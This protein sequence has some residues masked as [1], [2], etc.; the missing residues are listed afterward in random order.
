MAGQIFLIIILLIVLWL[1]FGKQ[2]QFLIAILQ[3]MI[4][5][6]ALFFVLL[7]TFHII[8]LEREK[9]QTLISTLLTISCIL[10]GRFLA[11][12]YL[13]RNTDSEDRTITI[14]GVLFAGL[15]AGFGLIINYLRVNESF[16]VLLYLNFTLM[17]LGFVATM[18]VTI[19]KHQ[20]EQKI[21]KAET[22]ANASDAE[23]K[24][25]QSQLSP[26]FL[27]NTLNNLYAL[28]IH[29]ASKLP[30][31]LLK[32]SDLLR[33]TVYDTKATMVTLEDEINYIKNYIDFEKIRLGERLELVA[34]WPENV[35]EAPPIAPMLLIVF[36]ENAFKHSK[37]T[38]DPR[39]NIAIDLQIWGKTL[40]FSVQNS[41]TPNL[42]EPTPEQHSGLGLENVKKRLELAYPNRHDL[43]IGQKNNTF[44]IKLRLT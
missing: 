37:N 13:S 7:F 8:D 33:Y 25:L 26:H 30:P 43:S 20:I 24:L 32:L 38:Q 22:K 23:L 35:A 21:T 12:Y 14:L 3:W 4:G 27:F 17:S 41:F 10:A 1:I 31:L 2:K 42:S 28:S 34:N 6:A 36:V 29:D 40:L 15:I 11:G 9:D 39:I 16:T 19:I 18:G 44:M 5:I